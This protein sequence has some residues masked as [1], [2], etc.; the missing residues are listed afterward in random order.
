MDTS[1]NNNNTKNDGNA[2]A[3]IVDKLE[4]PLKL[5]RTDSLNNNSLHIKTTDSINNNSIHNPLKKSLSVKSNNK[6]ISIGSNL[7]SKI[8]Y[9][10]LQFRN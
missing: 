10:L 3:N 1:N 5:K 6:Y 9:D 8:E 2:N 4:T 7:I